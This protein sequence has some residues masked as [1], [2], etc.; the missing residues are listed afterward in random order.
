MFNVYFGAV[1][2]YENGFLCNKVL[3]LGAKNWNYPF[4]RGDRGGFAYHEIS[5][6][7][8]YKY[9]SKIYEACLRVNRNVVKYGEDDKKRD[10]F[11]PVDTRFSLKE[12]Y[13]S[14][15]DEKDEQY[16]LEWLVLNEVAELNSAMLKINRGARSIQ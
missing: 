11:L 13:S 6:E 7:G 3:T 16:Y 2:V 8:T 5:M 10:P 15:V 12:I 1:Y 9:T 14:A 4:S